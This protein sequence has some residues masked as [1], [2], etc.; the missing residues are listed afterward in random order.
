MSTQNK[1]YRAPGYMGMPKLIKT[2]SDGCVV[3]S[4]NTYVD[5][6]ISYPYDRPYDPESGELLTEI[7]AREF[8]SYYDRANSKKAK[9]VSC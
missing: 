2:N 1:Y 3:V 4:Y 8:N 9:P 6:W 7:S 5:K